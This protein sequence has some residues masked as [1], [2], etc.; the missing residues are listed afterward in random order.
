MREAISGL[1]EDGVVVEWEQRLV[2]CH[3]VYEIRCRDWDAVREALRPF[4]IVEHDT[5]KPGARRVYNPMRETVGVYQP[6]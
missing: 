2:G 4:G 5:S 6:S 1:A 3:T